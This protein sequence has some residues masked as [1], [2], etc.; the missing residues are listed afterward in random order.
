[1]LTVSAQRQFIGHTPVAD[2]AADQIGHSFQI[3]SRAGRHH[4]DPGSQLF[5]HPP[6]QKGFDLTHAIRL[7][8]SIFIL[9]GQKSGYAHSRTPRNDSYLMHGIATTCGGN[10]SADNSMPGFMISGQFSI[11]VRDNDVPFFAHKDPALRA[12]EM[13]DVD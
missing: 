6:A 11:R 12:P 5:G 1:M 4:L 13:V 8:I 2:H 10:K 3:E 9:F 7:S